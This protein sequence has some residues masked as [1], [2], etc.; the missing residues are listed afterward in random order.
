MAE[1]VKEVPDSDRDTEDGT[2][3]SLPVAERVV[4]ANNVEKKTESGGDGKMQVQLNLKALEGD[5]RDTAVGAAAVGVMADAVRENL[6]EAG[7]QAEFG[8]FR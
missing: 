7:L 4:E 6:L 1:E 5:P 3:M 8:I 2:V